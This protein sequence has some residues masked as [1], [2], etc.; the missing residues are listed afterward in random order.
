MAETS[1]SVLGEVFCVDC[2]AAE[3]RRLTDLAASLEARLASIAGAETSP[4]RRLILVAL[5]LMDDVQGS[6]AALVRARREIDRLGDLLEQ[7]R[8]GAGAGAGR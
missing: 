3:A 1:V 4:Q 6:G 8:E 5:G 7:V 2:T